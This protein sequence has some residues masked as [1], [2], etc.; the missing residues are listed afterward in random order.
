MFW[1]IFHF[2]FAYNIFESIVEEAK[3]D[4]IRSVCNGD[5]GDGRVAH[6]ESYCG[7]L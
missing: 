4:G 5:G 1:E 6:G 3:K 2:V 7:L